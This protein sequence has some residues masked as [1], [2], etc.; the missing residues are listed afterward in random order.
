MTAFFF[1]AQQFTG[2]AFALSASLFT[3]QIAS[4]NESADKGVTIYTAGD[5][6]D[7]RKLSVTETPAAKTA[8]IIAGRLA[9]DPTAAVLTLGDNTYPIGLLAEFTDCYDKTWGQF[10]KRTYPA[11][12][13]HEYYTQSAAGYY[14][15]FGDAAG[16]SRRGYYSF[17]LG[18]WHVISLNSNLV[19][20]ANI[21]QLVWLKKDL[22]Q[23]PA[24]C[25]LAY[26]H[27]PVFSSGGH[28][29]NDIMRNAWKLLND[30]NADLVLVSHDHDYERFAPQDPDGKRDDAH[31][32]REFVVGTG[33]ARLSPFFLRKDNSEITFNDTHGV[34][35][36]VLKE[37]SYEWEF[38]PVAGSSFTDQGKGDCH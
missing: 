35:K 27:H 5:I 25:T 16:P 21:E 22:E 9:T 12:G 24:K 37:N 23:H 13:N 18:K 10:K 29:N 4:A 38:L 26:W 17:N 32:I 34:L 2:F 31:G 19:E 7:C 33:G 20:L 3:L 15:Y 14:E 11:P 1:R 8:A 6:A 28:G 30:A 36:L